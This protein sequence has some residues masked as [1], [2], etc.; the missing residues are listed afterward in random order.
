[1]KFIKQLSDNQFV[2][3]MDKQ[4]LDRDIRITIAHDYVQISGHDWHC[5]KYQ[6]KGPYGYA[7]VVQNRV[8]IQ[9]PIR[10]AQ[11]IL[12]TI[13]DNEYL[14]ESHLV[15]CNNAP[16]YLYDRGVYHYCKNRKKM[17]AIMDS[18]TGEFI[19]IPED[20]YNTIKS[21]CND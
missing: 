8:S 17:I 1:M 2:V 7:N 18:N 9:I 20:V 21:S 15:D 6:V 11:D 13:S 14:Q 5:E 3:E 12:K 4:D 19:H 16:R 10:A